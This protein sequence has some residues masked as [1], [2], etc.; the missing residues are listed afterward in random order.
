MLKEHIM[1]TSISILLAGCLALA[2]ASA[3]GENG[4]PGD[5]A[6]E[7]AT[8]VPAVV[9]AEAEPD[10]SGP[11]AIVDVQAALGKANQEAGINDEAVAKDGVKEGA[12]LHEDRPEETKNSAATDQ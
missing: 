12:M 6:L 5:S 10:A 9:N 7:D 8:R 3:F 2:A 11:T 1:K 4:T